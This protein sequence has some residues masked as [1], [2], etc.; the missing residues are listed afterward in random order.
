MLEIGTCSVDRGNSKAAKKVGMLGDVKTYRDTRNELAKGA[1]VTN[2][3]RLCEIQ[4]QLLAE[5]GRADTL[6][7]VD[8][9]SAAALFL[10]L[11]YNWEANNQHELAKASFLL[12]Y[13][14]S[15]A[16]G[17]PE[18]LALTA[19]QRLAQ[20]ESDHG[21]RVCAIE[22]ANAQEQLA[23]RLHNEAAQSSVL[24]AQALELKAEVL[25]EQGDPAAAARA[26]E[27]AQK[28]KEEDTCVGVCR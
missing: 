7:P 14:L 21:T 20:W 6:P 3:Q 24:G 12:S 5:T 13:Q 2:V 11:G 27:E 15:R 22:L 17:K 4:T 10:G 9:A 23:L 8:G 26:A 25:V 1:G 19:L 18:L 16:H 28:L